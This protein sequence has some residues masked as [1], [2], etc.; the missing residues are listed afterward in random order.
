LSQNATSSTKTHNSDFVQKQN[1]LLTRPRYQARTLSQQWVASEKQL[2]EVR[3]SYPMIELNSLFWRCNRDDLSDLMNVHAQKF[4]AKKSSIDTLINNQ[5]QTLDL[6]LTP[7]ILEANHKD[8]EI[9][10][11]EELKLLELSG[12]P[13][14]YLTQPKALEALQ[15]GLDI[16]S[17]G[18][19]IFVTGPSGC[20]KTSSIKSILKHFKRSDRPKYDFLYL[21]NF[22]DTDR[23]VLYQVEAGDGAKVK[24]L[25]QRFV[26][27][28]PECIVSA[29]NA[30]RVERKR[31]N[32]KKYLEDLYH[33]VIIEFQAA[34]QELGFTL[35]FE[36]ED[37][38][39][40][41]EIEVLIKR[42]KSLPLDEWVE[43]IQKG[44]I[45]N[46][47]EAKLNQKIKEHQEL[48]QD[49]QL[50]WDELSSQEWEVKRQLFE[51]ELRQ[52]TSN[53][54]HETHILS[55]YYH[56]KEDN[57]VLNQWFQGLLGW[58]ADHLEE[59]KIVKDEPLDFKEVRQLKV[60]LIHE[61]HKD[62]PIVFEQSPT[63]INLLGTIEKSGDD[64]HHHLDFADIRSGSLLKSNGGILV[65]N[66]NDM[67]QE[68]GTWRHL[69]RVLRSRLL[70]I[71]SP[72]QI[73]SS[74]GGPLKPVPIPLDVKVIAIG[75]DD[76]FR[77]LYLNSDDFA[78]VFK[79]KAEFEESV[80][81][82]KNSMRLYIAHAY[83]VCD[84]EGFKHCDLEAMALWIEN[85][86]RL[87]GSQDRLSTQ[88][89][90]LTDILRE[91]AFYADQE[92]QAEH[93]LAHHMQKAIQQRSRRHQLI[94]EQLFK[95]MQEK[96]IEIDTSGMQVGIVNALTVLDFADHTCGQPARISATHAPGTAGVISI[97]RAASLSGR[98][99]TKGAL[100]LNA[101]LRSHYIPDHICALT[102]SVAFDQLHD[103]IDGD[104]ASLAESL[105]LLS[106][107]AQVGL[108]QSIAI[109]GAI[110]Q[111]GHVQ[112]IG[113]VNEKIEGFFRI[114][115]YQGLTGKQ[116]VLIPRSII[117]DLALNS[118]VRQAVSEGMFFIRYIDHIDQA[119][120]ILSGLSAN[121]IEEQEHTQDYFTKESFNGRVR[122]RLVTLSHIAEDF[123]KTK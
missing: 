8:P 95:M 81:N 34:C 112:A 93:I 79:I 90:I 75:D 102:A 113:G 28:L 42:K 109:T 14:L 97:E 56:E 16:E 57:N 1:N 6:A 30:D 7:S 20:G 116:G 123:H 43:A 82:E 103:E 15:L 61:S 117:K 104:S 18:Y 5:Q 88:L 10:A 60:N 66:A 108:D 59:F 48:E 84:E 63:L 2:N 80:P 13:L 92:S 64:T 36:E 33:G 4:E 71:Q 37:D 105:A 91:A 96:L 70:E 40:T 50:L 86:T 49:L 68:S 11:Q 65:I 9:I 69:L 52:I 99:H 100:T 24:R 74:G 114:C 119:I 25:M 29:L 53:L 45:R 77:V 58:I 87:S 35:C 120:E 72:D 62:T 107:L 31:R 85:G 22:N 23:P 94:E 27:R 54:Q 55:P 17:P 118:T 121:G 19:H 111:R 101:Y 78:R 73:F 76:L 21:H 122:R 39:A 110:D 98:I 12:F 83:L 44:K 41:F 67:S 3:A 46:I 38:V 115:Q 47:D 106:S 51:Y 32:Y 26:E 89:G